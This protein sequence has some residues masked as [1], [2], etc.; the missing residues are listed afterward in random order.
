MKNSTRLVLA[1]LA[2]AFLEGRR[3]CIGNAS[4][5]APDVPEPSASASE[6]PSPR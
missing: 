4:G 6:S 2:I 1:L 5:I 3:G